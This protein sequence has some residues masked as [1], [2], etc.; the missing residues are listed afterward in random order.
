[1]ID[2]LSFNPRIA[3]WVPNDLSASRT[4]PFSLPHSAT[5]A[6]LFSYRITPNQS[7]KIAKSAVALRGL[8]LLSPLVIASPSHLLFAI[9]AY[10][11]LCNVAEAIRITRQ[12]TR[13]QVL[14]LAKSQFQ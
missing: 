12:L 9:P 1:M 14:A 2:G 8:D 13:I 5:P 10:K 11:K 6:S 3:G 4:W 7:F